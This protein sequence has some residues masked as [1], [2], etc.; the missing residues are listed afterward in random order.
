MCKLFMLL[1]S[2]IIVVFSTPDPCSLNGDLVNGKCV[3]DPGWKGN[4][5]TLLKLL[6]VNK[7]NPG[8]YNK[9][10]PTWSGANIYYVNNEYH[11]FVGAKAIANTSDD[12]Y[13]CN[14]NIIHLTSSISIN[15]PY[16]YKDVI[17]SRMHLSPF[18]TY[19]N[20]TYIIF[21]VGY[22]NV[23]SVDTCENYTNSTKSKVGYNESYNTIH[24]TYS[25]NIN[26]PL[27]EWMNHETVIYD[28]FPGT[29]NRTEWDC[30]CQ[31]PTSYIYPNGTT[32]LIFRGN[33]C[34]PYHGK[35]HIGIAI[36]S[37]WKGPYKKLLK[38]PIFGYNG[39]NEDPYLW[40]NK[41]GFHLLIHAQNNTG[42]N[43]TTRG[44]YAYSVDGISWILTNDDPWLPYI[45]WYDG[46]NNTLAR[47]Q[48]P[49]L[50]FDDNMNPIYLINGVDLNATDGSM[51]QTGWTLMNPI[52]K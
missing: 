3:C 5:C 25:S 1:L 50:V 14:S 18:I 45:L 15:G 7:S 2:L 44:G 24:L 29:I 38:D 4:N 8:Y 20:N 10:L 36:A 39:F 47:R 31:N 27:S 21:D 23:P 32:I 34:K 19:Y 28:P 37:H 13:L 35:N 40:R 6:P 42:E 49:G 11:W 52:G 17:L 9:S 51:W 16:K 41:R 26:D 48:K 33:Q 46:T 22:N 43:K 30:W 12:L